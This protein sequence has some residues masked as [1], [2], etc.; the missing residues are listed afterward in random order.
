MVR[1]MS[2]TL[3]LQDG[4]ERLG[5]HYMTAYRYVRLGL[6]PAEKIG[7]TWT[8]TEGDLVAFRAGESAG[9]LAAAGAVGSKI[10]RAH[11]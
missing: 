5:V 2:A 11:V 3:G 8:V 7:G 6:L 9:A 4:A 1:A 10:G